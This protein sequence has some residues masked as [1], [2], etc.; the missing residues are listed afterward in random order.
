MRLT[1]FQHS[2]FVVEKGGKSLI[3]DPGQ[4]SQDFVV[5]DDPV[6]CVVITHFH[7]DHLDQDKLRA[8]Q[9]KY[10]D[11]KVYAHQ[12]VIDALDSD[13]ANTHAVNAGSK[14]TVDGFTL[15]FSGGEH[16][17]IHPRI[18]MCANLCIRINEILYYPGDSF[19][20]PDRP[21]KVLALPIAA[22]WMKTA[23]GMDFLADVKPEI[24]FPI[25]DAVLSDSGKMFTDAWMQRAAVEVG[26]IYSRLDS[27]P[28]VIE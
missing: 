17:L 21:I 6:S 24:A 8:S 15:E 1:K 20:K 9:K 28:F 16:A 4:L 7:G 27:I 19:V 12:E 5:P 14:L 11:A 2:C 3:V 18:P 13:I 23:E 22:P 10:P 26:C 25:H